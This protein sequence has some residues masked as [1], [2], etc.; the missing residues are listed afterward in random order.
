MSPG[1]QVNAQ[2]PRALELVDEEHEPIK[3]MTAVALVRVKLE[4]SVCTALAVMFESRDTG[5]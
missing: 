3:M 5:T 4:C 1:Q 2:E